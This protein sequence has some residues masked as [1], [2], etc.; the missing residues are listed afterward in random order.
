MLDVTDKDGAA[1][2]WRVDVLPIVPDHLIAVPP[3]EVS[4]NYNK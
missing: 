1:K 3:A 4:Y 2:V